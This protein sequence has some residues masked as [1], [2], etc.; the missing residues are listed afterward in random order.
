M[1][2]CE[3]LFPHIAFLYYLSVFIQT[4]HWRINTIC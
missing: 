4:Q 2:L 3:V 1:N